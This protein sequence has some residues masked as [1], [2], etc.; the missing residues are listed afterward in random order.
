MPQRRG[1]PLTALA[2][3][4][5][6]IRP[7]RPGRIANPSSRGLLPAPPSPGKRLP[8]SRVDPQQGLMPS[9][10]DRLIDPG[11]G[12]TAWRR[13]YGVEQMID[14]VRRDLEDLLHTRPTTPGRPGGFG[15]V[16]N[17]VIGYGLPDL[18][19]LDAYTHEQRAAIGRLIE[20]AIERYEPRLRGVQATMLDPGDGA[21]RRVRFRIDARLC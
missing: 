16:E 12:G 9:L 21:E 13:G 1:S 4:G 6:A 20:A 7:F 18:T 17:S 8:M 11:S 14:A 3:D 2:S 15:E 19:T 5:F 10:L